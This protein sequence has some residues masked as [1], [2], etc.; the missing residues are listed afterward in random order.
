MEVTG[1]VDAII[2][3]IKSE[4]IVGQKITA[5]VAVGATSISVENSFHYYPG[6]EVVMIDNDY[7]NRN[8]SRYNSAEYAVVRSVPDTNTINL[9]SPLLRDYTVANGGQIQKAIAHTPLFD[10]DVLFGDREVIPEDKISI[11]VEPETM[12]NEWIYLQGGL[13]EETRCKITIYGQ[14]A[15]T[16][17][18]MR[19]LAA[20]SKAVYDILIGSLHLNINDNQTPLTRDIN[21]GDTVFCI[22]NTQDNLENFVV[23]TNGELYLFQD[24]ETP[25]C[26]R[27]EIT[28]RVISGDEICL[29][30]SCPFLHS[31][32]RSEFAVASRMRRYMYDTRISDITYGYVQK[33]SAFLRAAELSWF[34][35]E[36]NEVP[37]P[38]A[39]RRVI[40]FDPDD[41]CASSS[42]D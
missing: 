13:S 37:F 30:V 8:S 17:N 16:E 24:N 41:V 10:R 20:Y 27:Y 21:A 31:Y 22:C 28:D 4:L 25:R 33:G 12:T 15:E 7:M 14:N 1:I 11:T 42:S 39:D 5:D 26:V 18:G 3:S 29:T 35:K 38:Q 9:I 40:C 32:S 2:D 19:I 36:V 6:Q 23:S 34:G